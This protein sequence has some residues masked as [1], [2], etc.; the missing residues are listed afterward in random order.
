[1]RTLTYAE[2]IREGFAQLLASD[3]RVFVI[4][5]GVWSP[6]Y[7]GT[8]LKDLDKEFGRNRIID[9]PVSENATTGAAIGAAR[10]FVRPACFD[11]SNSH[12][13]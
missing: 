12:I 8:S 7:A 13:R 9:S 3:P 6:W 4:G 10:S 1:M 5:Q 11:S 2:A